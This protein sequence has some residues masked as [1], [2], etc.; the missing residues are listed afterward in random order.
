MDIKI[1]IFLPLLFAVTLPFNSIRVRNVATYI[2]VAFLMMLS[3][4]IFF[5][6]QKSTISS[7]FPDIF[8][9]VF[10]I[11]DIVLL[12]YFL[13]Q[14]V[15]NKNKL[16]FA[17]AF[18]QIV[19]FVFVIF[20]TPTQKSYDMIVDFSSLVML[21][22]V[23]IVGGIIIIYA[24]KYIQNEDFKECKKNL[25]IAILFFFLGVMNLLVTT[26][27]IEIFFFAFELTTLC[28]YLLIRYREDD[29]AIANAL[30]ALWMNQIGAVFIL[31][32]LL[33]GIYFYDTI[34]FDIL[35]SII[36]QHFLVPLT[37]LIVAAF[38]KGA[39][40]PFDKWLVGAMVAP[41]PVSAILHSAT[42]VKIAPYLILKLSSA[43][44]PIL[45]MIVLLFGSFIF[46]SASLLALSK[47]FFKEILG[48]S[49]IA[50]LGLMMAIAAIGTKEST[51]IV[52][53]L[54]VFHAISKALLFFQAGML[55][56]VYHL[57]YLHDID[58]LASRSK[59]IVFFILVGFASLTLPPFGAFIGKFSSIE[60]LCSLIEQNILYLFPFVFIL[61]GS[62]F[63][64]LLY[65][66]VVTKLLP[67]S[68]MKY[69]KVSIPYTY[70]LSSF[71]LV[72]LL[73]YGVYISY[74]YNF[75]GTL[76]LLVSSLLLII[77]L[78]MLFVVKLKNIKRVKEYNCGEKD[79]R[80]LGAF[81]FDISNRYKKLITYGAILFICIVV[82]VGVV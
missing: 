64:T 74:E 69:E 58:Y 73:I 9:T 16:V 34:Y 57:K 59:L 55:E 32:S 22:V 42:M 75:L 62:V 13:Y 23:N 46:M 80:E 15:K 1:L 2:Y 47:D 60:L 30:L 81:Y 66:K 18:I 20:A 21:L 43:F 33:V 61:L 6:A 52:L 65:F 49:T 56:K 51:A 68:D 11:L 72:S 12:L 45:S 35:L 41:T 63:L 39:S 38:V 37:L 82:F 5:T 48:Y 71:F 10:I 36:D 76:E 4:N 27:N 79:Q 26:N 78:A 19:L 67:K 28:S 31:L 14:G 44:S 7:N 25:F 17:F 54:I 53:I 77:T 3:L 40:I 70:K 8:H 29:I 50:L 24:L